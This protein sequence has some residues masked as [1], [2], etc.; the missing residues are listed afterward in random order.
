MSSYA[1]I[2]FGTQKS[3]KMVSSNTLRRKNIQNGTLISKWGNL[4]S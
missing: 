1:E 4:P 2:I 3:K